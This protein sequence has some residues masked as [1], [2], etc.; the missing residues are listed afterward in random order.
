A[1]ATDSGKGW[2]SGAKGGELAISAVREREGIINHSPETFKAG[3]RFR[4]YVSL[5]TDS[6]QPVETEVVVFQGR[7]IHFPYAARPKM[8]G[9]NMRP[10]PDAFQFT[11]AQSTQVCIAAG[12]NLPSRQRILQLGKQALPISTVCIRLHPE[13]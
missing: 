6:D 7:E 1:P 12:D 3:D 13:K 8:Y 4:L 9:G 10:L 5:P 2:Y 11:G